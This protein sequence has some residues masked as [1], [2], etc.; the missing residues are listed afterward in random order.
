MSIRFYTVALVL[1][2][3]ATFNSYAANHDN[4]IE[5]TFGEVRYVDVDGG[6]G[7][8][9]GGS[10]RFNEQFY[11]IAGFQD[12]DG[13]GVS[14]ELFEF[15]GGIIFPVEKMDFVGEISLINADVPGDSDTGLALTGGV[16]SFITPELEGRVNV[17]YEDLFDDS[18]TFIE[19]GGDY[20][21]AA[22]LSIGA[23]LELASEAD[24]FTLGGRFYF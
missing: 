6:D 8:E 5:Y 22:N 3:A 16:R 9:I 4:G 18:D 7:I 10:F 23:T 19:F 11:G 2:I 20:F 15:G 13:G 21:L 17:R 1:S 14:V 12:L 24:R